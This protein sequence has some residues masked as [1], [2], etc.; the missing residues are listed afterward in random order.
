MNPQFCVGRYGFTIQ[1]QG[2]YLVGPNPQ[3]TVL[4]GQLTAEE[5]AAIQSEV[6]TLSKAIL[7][8]TAQECHATGGI[9]GVSDTIKIV[10]ANTGQEYVLQDFFNRYCG[11]NADIAAKFISD[12]NALTDKYYPRPF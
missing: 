10:L 11:A 12:I 3:N 7:N 4:E 2:H 6:D 1:N 8:G 5:S 9:A